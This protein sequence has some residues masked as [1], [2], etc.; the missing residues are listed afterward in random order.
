MVAALEPYQLAAGFATIAMIVAAY[1]TFLSYRSYKATD[2]I[3]LMFVVMAFFVIAL[4][5]LLT[6]LNEWTTP[7]YMGEHEMMMVA[8]AM[9][10]VAVMLLFI[11]FVARAS[12]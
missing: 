8:A 9:D 2:N 5:S 10:V 6:A 4:K 3:K 1:L 12:R 11:P 7:H